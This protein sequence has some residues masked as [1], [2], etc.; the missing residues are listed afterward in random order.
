MK[1][2]PPLRKGMYA[3]YSAAFSRMLSES[4]PGRETVAGPEPP[5]GRS[6]AML[7]H[8]TLGDQL[9]VVDQQRFGDPSRLQRMGEQRALSEQLLIIAEQRHQCPPPREPPQ[10]VPV[11]G[12]EGGRSSRRHRCEVR[13]PSQQ[14][15][16]RIGELR[17]EFVLVL[18]GE[19]LAEGER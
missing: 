15:I 14:P 6:V 16:D 7:V 3:A 19:A 13:G 18:S 12:G 11:I 5:L 4:T 8:S 9:A 10:G 17:L 2:P 1:M